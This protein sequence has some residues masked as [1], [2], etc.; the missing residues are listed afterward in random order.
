MKSKVYFANLHF[1]GFEDN[2]ISKIKNLF[3]KADFKKLI[4]PKDLTAIKV[5]FG[6]KGNTS[7]VPPWYV[8][9]IV[10]KVIEAGGDPFITDTTTLYSGPRNN[11]VGHLNVANEHGFN[12][13]WRI[14]HRMSETMFHL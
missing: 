11:A 14:Y 2:L 5:H 7:F 3:D 9:A 4:S 12:H 1:E 6:E 8:R 10:D 13:Y